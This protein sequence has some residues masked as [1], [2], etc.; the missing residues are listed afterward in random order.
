MNARIAAF[1]LLWD[2]TVLPPPPLPPP[3]VRCDNRHHLLP[4]AEL[5]RWWTAPQAE[6]VEMMRLNE[7]RLD[8]ARIR[9]EAG[10]YTQ[11]EL[12]NL[13][14]WD[15]PENNGD[16]APPPAPLIAPLL[17]ENNFVVVDL[18]IGE[19]DED[20]GPLDYHDYLALINDEDD[21]DEDA[22]PLEYE[23]EDADDPYDLDLAA[24]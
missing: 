14:S 4:A 7:I 11:E 20:E 17:A 13:A 24:Y 19:D 10:N 22:D 5:E 3:L 16:W 15:P 9:R 8:A 21:H 12:D 1:Q 2:A 18:E 6:R 23:D